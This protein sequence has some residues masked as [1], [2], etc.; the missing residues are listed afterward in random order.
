LKAYIKISKKN[1]TKE[2]EEKLF[3]LLDEHGIKYYKLSEIEK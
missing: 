1:A 3:K 2:D